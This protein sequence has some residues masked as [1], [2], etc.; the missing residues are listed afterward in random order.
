MRLPPPPAGLRQSASQDLREHDGIV[1]LGVASGVNEC[2][3]ALPRPA[4]KLGDSRTL[5]AKLFDVAS[6][7]L[8]EAARLVPEPPPEL[9][10]WWQLALPLVELGAPARDPARPETVDQDAIAI[11]GLSGLIGAF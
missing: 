10:T 6:A 4:P 9:G 2:E 5:S 11:R 1:V 7:K 8:L 3:R